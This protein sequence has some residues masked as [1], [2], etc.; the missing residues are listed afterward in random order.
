M[1]AYSQAIF[2]DAKSGD[3]RV[4]GVQS[5]VEVVA[6]AIIFSV[7]LGNLMYAQDLYQFFL[8]RSSFRTSEPIPWSVLFDPDPNFEQW[9][10]TEKN[11]QAIG[12]MLKYVGQYS[13][14][15]RLLDEVK[16]LAPNW[17]MPDAFRLQYHTK[18]KDFPAAQ[19]A[20]M[21]RA[22]TDRA[23]SF[24]AAIVPG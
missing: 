16:S 15:E 10:L 12:M 19:A 24:I 21:A 2:W 1:D 9:E 17:L 3:W 7:R 13:K 11:L 4:N 23:R 22:K 8:R 18:D 5:E 20:L 6:D 14:D